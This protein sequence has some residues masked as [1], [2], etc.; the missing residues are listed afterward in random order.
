MDKE[1]VEQTTEKVEEESQESPEEVVESVEE[2]TEVDPL[3]KELE[4]KNR[5]LFERAKKAETELKEKKA[6]Q[7]INNE[8]HAPSSDTYIDGD[9]SQIA[10]VRR[11]IQSLKEERQLES[12]YSEYPD[13]KDK[14]QEFDEFKQDYPMDK[15]KSA[16]KLFLLENGLL[17][18]APKRKGLEPAGRGTRTKPTS[19]KMTAD[20]AKRLREENYPK[21]REMLKAGKIKVEA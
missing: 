19:N 2:E 15:W 3:V 11:E 16:A 9:T 12:I 21:Y 20:D 6:Q 4:D 10:D 17:E 8:E 13:L 1:T 5:Q 14:M 7:D 18:S